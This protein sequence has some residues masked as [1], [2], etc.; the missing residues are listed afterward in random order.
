MSSP[1]SS[2]VESSLLGSSFSSDTEV[3]PGAGLEHVQEIR[4]SFPNFERAIADRFQA[5]DI[6]DD[7]QLWIV[8][9]GFDQSKL[10]YID[11]Y[12]N[13]QCYHMRL[14]LDNGKPGDSKLIVKMVCKPHEVMHRTLMSVIKDDMKL[15]GLKELDDFTDLGSGRCAHCSD[16]SFKEA[17]SSIVP[18]PSPE[19]WPSLVAEAGWSESVSRLRIDAQW[20]LSA[21]LP[22]ENTRLVVL[23]SFKESERTFLLQRYELEKVRD[24]LTRSATHGDRDVGQCTAVTTIDLRSTPPTITGAPFELPFDKIM[25]RPARALERDVSLSEAILE[26]WATHM[27]RLF[28]L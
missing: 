28:N 14:Q 2:T 6:C 15:M 19:A 24:R 3:Q 10:K 18:L 12:I 26:K 1:I 4:F 8:F 20:W 13:E 22:P 5:S 16:H 27:A 11:Q 7:T 23:I 17:D 21:Q 9:S 25:R